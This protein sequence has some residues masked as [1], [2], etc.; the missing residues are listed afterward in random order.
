MSQFGGTLCAEL[1]GGWS[2]QSFSET[3]WLPSSLLK[4]LSQGKT[5]RPALAEKSKNHRN[6]S[7]FRVVCPP[8][9]VSHYSSLRVGPWHLLKI[10]GA[11]KVKAMSRALSCASQVHLRF[12][13]SATFL[14]LNATSSI[15]R[16]FESHLA[17]FNHIIA[18][19]DCAQMCWVNSQTKSCTSEG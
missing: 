7:A 10:S 5:F 1:D 16:R 11:S 8:L 19:N 15:A 2:T 18:Y 13:R 4:D 3:F 12:K 14:C 17:D 6:M 9:P